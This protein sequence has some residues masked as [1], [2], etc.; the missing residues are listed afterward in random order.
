M[1]ARWQKAAFT[2][3]EVLI[4]VVIMAI[5]AS[6]VIPN[7]GSTANHAKESMLVS[8]THTLRSQIEIYRNDHGVYPSL[9]GNSLP[10]L[11][12]TT[13]VTGTE[14]ANGPFGPYFDGKI[15]PNPVDQ[16]NA[17]YP[18]ASDP[19]NSTTAPAKG[20][21]YHEASGGLWPNNPAFWEN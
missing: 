20:W 19:P 18:T 9:I 8:T 13:D 6:I 10:Q 15:P 12:T 21:Q 16:S 17:I 4:V 2:L 11:V 5:L 7:L 1:K 14:V 3:I